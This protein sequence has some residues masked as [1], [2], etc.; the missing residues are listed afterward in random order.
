MLPLYEKTTDLFLDKRQLFEVPFQECH[1]F[2][3]SLA[4][5]VS[6][7][8]VVLFADLVQLN[9]QLNHLTN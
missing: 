4:V 3:L 9:L 8:I 6:D 1:L 2:L 7:D 5:A